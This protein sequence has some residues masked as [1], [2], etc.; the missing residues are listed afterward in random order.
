MKTPPSSPP[1]YGYVQLPLVRSEP[2]PP[3]KNS[4]PSI[5]IVSPK[6][7]TYPV[8]PPIPPRRSSAPEVRQYLPVLPPP[9]PPRSN[10]PD[11]RQ[12]EIKVDGDPNGQSAKVSGL[13][14]RCTC[15]QR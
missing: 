1:H 5:L 8:P 13:F 14:D 3:R 4:A 11:A 12:R 2:S 7:E 9:I 10:I 6:T 15:V